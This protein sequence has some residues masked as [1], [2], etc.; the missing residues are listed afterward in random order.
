MKYFN[1]H[2][3]TIGYLRKSSQNAD[4]SRFKVTNVCDFVTFSYLLITSNNKK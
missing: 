3:K 4:H 2:A 1:A